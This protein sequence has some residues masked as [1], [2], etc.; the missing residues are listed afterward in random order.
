MKK[1]KALIAVACS[2]TILGVVAASGCSAKNLTNVV[3]Y[4]PPA[5]YS[6]QLVLPFDL[7]NIYYSPY[8][9]KSEIVKLNGNIYVFKSLDVTKITMASIDKGYVWVDLVKAYPLNPANLK[10]LRLGEKIDVAGVLAGPCPDFPKSL[11][12]TG[13]VFLP[14]GSVTLPLNGDAPLQYTPT[15]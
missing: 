6:G 15:Y 5:Y 4:V 2:M 10:Q 13:V 14:A 9:P 11:T 1:L 12:F 8:S 3:P 7:S